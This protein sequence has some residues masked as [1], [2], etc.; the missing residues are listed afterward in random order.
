MIEALAR[1]YVVYV[2]NDFTAS[3]VLVCYNL[4]LGFEDMTTRCWFYETELPPLFAW[5]YRFTN[6]IREL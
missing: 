5:M 2:I 6:E 1:C 3:A 4:S